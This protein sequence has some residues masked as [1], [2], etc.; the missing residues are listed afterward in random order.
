MGITSEIY[1][2]KKFI[3][4]E[5]WIEFIKTISHYNGTFRKWKIIL[6]NHQNQIQYFVKTRRFLPTSINHLDG[7]LLK[8][9]EEIPRPKAN[10]TVL[11]LPK[12]NQN[13]LDLINDIEIKKKGTLTYLEINF[14]KL[15]SHRIQSTMTYYMNFKGMV[16]KYKSILT[17]PEDI[18]SINFEENKRYFY[19]SAPKY[20]E[21]NKILPLLSSEDTNA[22]L[23]VDTF[24]Y[25]QGNYYLNQ[26]HFHFDKHSI[27]LGS[28]GSGK[29]KL[30]SLLISNIYKNETLRKNY[31]I[32]VIDPH[33]SLEEDIGGIGKVIDFQNRFDSID[34]FM[35]SREDIISSTELLL[36]LLKSLIADQYNSK[37]E[38]ILRHSIHV[39]LTNESFTF[40]NLR[41]LILDLEYRNELLKKLTD[42][43]PVSVLD[44]FFSDFNDLKTKSY[45]E[46]ISPIIS[47]IDEMEMI[48]VFHLENVSENLKTTIQ[49]NFLT[50]FSLDRTRLGNKVTKTIAGLLMQQLLTIMQEKKIDEHVIFIVDEVSA[51]ENPILT[52]FLSEARKYHLSLN[53]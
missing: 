5:E 1:L 12:M 43:L 10:Y 44:F 47:F 4:K 38:R 29:S 48:P 33:A 18:L 42:H 16:K 6:T 11:F 9:T 45:G 13:I 19:K 20:L 37:I 40:R 32:I 49:D 39:L 2:S 25:L 15:S 14:I 46:A 3:S 8:K 26:N 7:F 31:K 27:I 53:F 52:R 24:P 23:S 21:I 30:I 36:D 50:L 17:I 22:L 34:L 35:N 51:V 41:R 28:S